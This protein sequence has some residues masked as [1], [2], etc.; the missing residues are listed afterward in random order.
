MNLPPS[1][2][3]F[4]PAERAPHSRPDVRAG[5]PPD[6][7]IQTESAGTRLPHACPGRPALRSGPAAGLRVLQVA[8][9]TEGGVGRH[10]L[11]LCHGLALRGQHVQLLYSPLRMDRA[12]QTRLHELRGLRGLSLQELPIRREVDRTDLQAVRGVRHWLRAHGPYDLV[13]GHS[14]KGGAIARLAALVSGVPAVYTPHAIKTMDPGLSGMARIVVGRVER[15]LSRVPGLIIAVSPGEKQHLATLGI[16]PDRVRVV[17]NGIPSLPPT[18]RAD[19]RAALDLPQDVP[20]IGFVG[21]LSRQKAPDVLLQAFHQVANQHATALLAVVGGGVMEPVLREQTR[22]LGIASRIRWL[23]ER[24]GQTSMPA[25]DVLALPSRYEAF[26]YVLVEAAAAGVPVVATSAC[27]A[28]TVLIHNR[29]GY[30]VPVADPAA[31]SAQLLKILGDGWRRAEFARA[32]RQLAGRFTLERMVTE[33][34]QVY[35][36]VVPGHGPA[37]GANP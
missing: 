4:H 2:P 35:A 22:Q 31:L 13:H 21:R 3:R 9:A 37:E 16:P 17:A 20:V 23:G 10:V 12:F 34:W 18:S 28:G 32:A 6:G 36:E 30:V 25:F 14:S 33:T 24:P 5:N 26:P 15:L 8:E 29:N 19:A 1:E 7:A 27:P 11:D